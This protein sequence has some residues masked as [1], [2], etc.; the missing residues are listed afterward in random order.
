MSE[1][2][3]TDDTNADVPEWKKDDLPCHVIQ[4]RVLLG[5]FVITMVLIIGSELLR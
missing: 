2:N 4:G 1:Q 3:Q 5:V